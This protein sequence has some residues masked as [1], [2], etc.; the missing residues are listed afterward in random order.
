MVWCAVA[1]DAVALTTLG[2]E[3]LFGTI[4][5]DATEE[6]YAWAVAAGAGLA[7]SFLFLALVKRPPDGEA[8][9]QS[10][11]AAWHLGRWSGLD[12]VLSNAGSLLPYFV[13]TLVIGGNTAGIYR[14]LQSALGPLNIVHVTAM[15]SFGLDSWQ[16]ATS[17]GLTALRRKARR[18][19]LGMLGASSAYVMIG[20]PIMVL[21]ANLHDP[22]I[23]R[24]S[25]IIAIGGILGSTNT[26]QN[27]GAL[28][29]GYQWAGVIIRGIIVVGSVVI[30][31]P[32]SVT[33]W[34]PWS[35]AIGATWLMSNSVAL[36]GWTFAYYRAVQKEKSRH[37]LTHERLT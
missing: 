37:E 2:S 24:L 5:H 35:D 23:V 14:T 34:V 19:T 6:L 15:T 36:I 22:H 12:A 33:H 11:R 21:I 27:A 3:A 17:S 8:P 30:S 31:L 26:A 20:I 18:L 10:L 4:G 25:L 29:L 32:W 7:S 13:A 9:S 16:A 1:A 28:V